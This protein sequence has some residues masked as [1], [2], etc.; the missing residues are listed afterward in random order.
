MT[1]TEGA[2]VG[3]ET[4][5][6][7]MRRTTSGRGKISQS[8]DCSVRI[9]NRYTANLDEKMEQKDARKVETARSDGRIAAAFI[10]IIDDVV[11]QSIRR[12]IGGSSSSSNGSLSIHVY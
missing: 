5:S 1:V 10:M 4:V 6:N 3:E 2:R 12:L 9:T 7:I 8:A 11:L